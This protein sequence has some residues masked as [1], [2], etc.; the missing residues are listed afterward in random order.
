M[1]TAIENNKKSSLIKY[2]K[3]AG[4]VRQK[5]KVYK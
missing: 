1:K 2:K 5:I 3:Y 4:I